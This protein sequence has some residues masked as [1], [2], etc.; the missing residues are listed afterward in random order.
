MVHFPLV[1]FWKIGITGRSATARAADID[2]AM[3]GFPVPVFIVVVPGAYG[4]EQ[5]LHRVCGWLR[6]EFYKGTGHSEWFLFP[7]V[8]FALPVMLLIWGLY[9]FLIGCAMQWDAFGWYVDFLTV[10]AYWFLGLFR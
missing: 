6:V 10:L 1:V 5:W 9:F 8:I 2:E 7:A 3:F 4:V